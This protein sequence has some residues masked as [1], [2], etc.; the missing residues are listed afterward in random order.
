M[1]FTEWPYRVG[2][3]G[4]SQ[5]VCEPY[6]S[7]YR[8][9]GMVRGFHETKYGPAVMSDAFVGSYLDWNNDGGLIVVCPD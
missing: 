2:V 4:E 9:I 3:P 7:G 5:R 6:R 8:Y 1:I